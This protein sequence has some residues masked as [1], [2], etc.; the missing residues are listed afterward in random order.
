MTHTWFLAAV[1]LA[2]AA[3]AF[4]DDAGKV[5]ADARRTA[6]NVGDEMKHGVDTAKDKLKTDSG[7]KK[8]RRHAA[9]ARRHMKKNMRN[10]THDIRKD[11]GLPEKP[12]K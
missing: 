8:A 10:K 6:K 5:K 2:L 12:E 4:G 11:A 3:P 7:A 1:G 9:R